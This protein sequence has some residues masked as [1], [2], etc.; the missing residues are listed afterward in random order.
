MKRIYLAGW[1]VVA[2][3]GMP[4]AA[5]VAVVLNSNDDDI[6]LIDTR[7]YQELRRTPIG[8]GPHHLVPTPDGRYI[9]V[10]N[11]GSND[12]VFL[13]ATT[14]DVA[15]RIGRIPDPYHLGFSPDKQWLVINANRLDRV[16]LYRYQDGALRLAKSLS[17]ARTPS[18]MAFGADSRTVYVSLQESNQVAAID[19]ATQS[20]RWRVGTGRQP[21][22]VWVTPDGQKVL[23][24]ITGEDYVEALS[25]DDG[26]SLARIVT[27]K[28]AHSFLPRGDGRHVF[29]SNRV[30]NTISLID[31]QTLAVTHSF[32]VPGG[33]DDMELKHDGSELWVTSR[34]ANRVS[35]VDLATYKLK[36]SI[37]VGRSPHGLYFHSHAPRR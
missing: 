14:G 12:L 35:V 22:G 13:D 30:A 36:H 5:E 6:S 25:P 23:V 33:P 10:G 34:W 4:A 7:S 9:V 8:K 24:A 11:T 2:G 3:F 20:V 15:R 28:G 1:L 27:G 31:Q 26:R 32:P 19:L 29:L 16:D 17:L 21:A 18:H 37:R